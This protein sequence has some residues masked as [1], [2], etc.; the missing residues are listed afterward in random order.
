MR[1]TGYEQIWMFLIYSFLGWCLEV[2]Y[3]AAG[4]KK[5]VN[6]GEI[7]RAHV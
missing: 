7:G 5:F 2:I 3:A 4:H 1:Y 6:R